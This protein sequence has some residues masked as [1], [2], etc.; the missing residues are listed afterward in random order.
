M[1]SSS[2]L[3]S[4]KPS[5]ELQDPIPRR[6]EAPVFAGVPSRD[7]DLLSFSNIQG[8]VDLLAPN[9]DNS[10]EVSDSEV[11]HWVSP[12]QRDHAAFYTPSSIGSGGGGGRTAKE[13]TAPPNVKMKIQKGPAITYNNSDATKRKHNQN[14]SDTVDAD[15]ARIGKAMENKGNRKTPKMEVLYKQ[16]VSTEDV[17][18]GSTESTPSTDCSQAQIVKIDLPGADI[19][20]VELEVFRRHILVESKMF[21]LATTLPNAVK[22]EYAK[23]QWIKKKEQLIITVQ[24]LYT[25]PS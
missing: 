14:S 12:C 23:A 19:K 22:K 15:A 6:R 1:P 9:K 13:V 20:N 5:V 21:L 2:S 7:G 18:L 10:S 4:T 25:H 17:Y 8:L 3:E 24:I 16:Y 11:G